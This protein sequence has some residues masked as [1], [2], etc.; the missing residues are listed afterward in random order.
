LTSGT[1]ATWFA[2]IAGLQSVFIGKEKGSRFSIVPTAIIP[3]RQSKALFLKKPILTNEENKKK[4]VHV[5]VNHSKGQY[6]DGKGGH[7]NGMENF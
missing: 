2:P 1:K 7:T 5:K 4:Y 6:S 3:S